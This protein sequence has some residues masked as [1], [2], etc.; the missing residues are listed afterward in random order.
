M[1]GELADFSSTSH[2][3]ERFLPRLVVGG[4]LAT[5]VVGTI[6]GF[7]AEHRTIAQSTSHTNLAA[8]V[9]PPC[10][11]LSA[12]AAQ[13]SLKAQGV[14]LKYMFDFNGDTFGRVFGYAD[15]SVAAS[16]N[17]LGSYDVCQ[18]ISP[19]VLYVKTARREVYFAP[20]MGRKATV[21]TADGAPRCI[22]AAPA[23]DD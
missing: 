18:F 21:T 19:A 13:R 4:A 12:D 7:L 15:C 5:L 14:T 6:W 3:V 16:S 11:T 22:M 2:G 9:G 20:G 8:I 1:K 17:G 23:W 10:P